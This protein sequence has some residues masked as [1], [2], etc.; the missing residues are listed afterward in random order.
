M[1]N[2]A[3][4]AFWERLRYRRQFIFGPRAAALE[5]LWRTHQVA[6][7]WVLTAQ[8]DLP[9]HS[10]RAADGGWVWLVGFVIDPE[11]PELGD[12]ALL[13]RLAQSSNWEQ[14]IAGTLFLS[15]RWVLFHV[16]DGR[17]RVVPNATA[18]RTVY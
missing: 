13:H 14:L 11:T 12:E 15:G 16:K 2:Q 4:R 1:V 7:G 6:P 18:L 5:G 8:Q 3:D 10:A 17:V 9:V